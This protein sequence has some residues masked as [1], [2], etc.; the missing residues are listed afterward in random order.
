MSSQKT[1]AGAA[2]GRTKGI[3]ELVKTVV[4]AVLIALVVRSLAFEPFN[5]PSSSMKPTLLI[6]DYLF[7]SKFS[8]GYS[9]HSFPLSL[10]PFEG[11][12]LGA[13]PERGDVVVF[14][15]P[16]DGRTDYIKRVIGLPGDRVQVRRGQLYLNGEVVPRQRLGTFSDD[17]RS[18]S[19]CAEPILYRET[20]PGGRGHEILDC[21]NPAL[22]DNTPLFTVP[23][24][25]VFVMGDNRDNSQDSRYAGV[26]FVPVENLVGEAQM[27]FFSTNQR[28]AWWQIWR[29]PQAIRFNRLFDGIE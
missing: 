13:V 18:R 25:H 27:I 19:D 8:Y 7:V 26:G 1:T 29:W 28:A 24:A 14:K 3:I 15:L 22:L 20:L 16:S 10:P 17:F 6:G 11:R 4:Y 9:R 2:R 12:V 23:D 21:P 5:I